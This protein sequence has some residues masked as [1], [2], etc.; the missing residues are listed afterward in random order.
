MI[1]QLLLA[2]M[3]ASPVSPPSQSDNAR[4]LVY[5]AEH[6]IRTGRL[7]QAKVMVARAMAAGA[8]GS[9]L[10]R[11]LAD[12]AY[13]SG[14]NEEAL[15][16]YQALL[17]SAPNDQ[18]YLEP[19]GIAAL[20]M[21]NISVAAEIL[22]TATSSPHA[23]WR[24]WN[25]LGV[26]ADFKS[27]WALADRCFSRAMH[28]APTE[29]APVNNQ[30]WSLLSRGRWSEAI[31]FLEHAVEIDPHSSRAANN[32]ELARAALAADLPQRRSGETAVSWAARLNDA[33][34]AAE[35][36]GDKQRALAAFSRSL[37]VSD[38]WY[39]RAA[40]NLAALGGK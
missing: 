14:H 11:T 40:N 38:V 6:A 21:G 34:V 30:G 18:D 37:E 7:D 29:A 35:I 22:S 4:Q 20:R 12:L 5:G 31:P 39:G 19:A 16:R 2:V 1:L 8:T 15:T 25:A 3:S 36:L 9:E 32:L 13:A 24:A 23:H 33:G 17:K 26:A 10:D 27:D 28:L